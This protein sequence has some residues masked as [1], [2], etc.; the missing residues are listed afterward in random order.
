MADGHSGIIYIYTDEEDKT[1]ANKIVLFLNKNI[2]KFKKMNAI[3]T[4]GKINKKD[5]L[6]L[7]EAK[8]WKRIR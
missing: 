5:I 8:E 3:I 7:E 1:K 2:K 6:K 4:L